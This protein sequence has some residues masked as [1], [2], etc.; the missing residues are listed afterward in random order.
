[1]TQKVLVCDSIDPASVE[2]MKA[3][4]LSVDVRTG[5]SAKELCEVVGPY[6]ALVVRS[7]TKVTKDVLERATSL[8][9]VVRGG[10]GVDNIA[11][12]DARRRGVEVMNT[13]EANSIAVAEHAIA[14]MFAFSRRIAAADVSMRAG[15]W[16]KAKLEGTEL[17][18]KTL[19]L[20]GLGRIATEVARRAVA[21]GMRV[22]ACRRSV[23]P[24]EEMTA[25]GVEVV[26]FD[27]LL[28]RADIVSLHLPFS[29]E[30]HHLFDAARIARMK[31][32]A[33]LVNCARGGI[34]DEVAL[35]QAL[36]SGHLSGAAVDVFEKEPPDPANPLL[37]LPNVVVTPHLGASTVEGQNRVG[38]AVA[39]KVI[40]FFLAPERA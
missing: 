37:R 27:D 6:H 40:A 38:E 13:P 12:D 15:R 34:V 20:V 3:A 11:V 2:E 23:K 17:Y 8:K 21:L 16:D 18:R 19:G 35:A 36:E 30:S 4:G 22:I 31:Q 32:G 33:V 25:L 14:L 7:A 28:A 29:K 5:L 26:G 10:V 39:R 9:L 24:A 1:M